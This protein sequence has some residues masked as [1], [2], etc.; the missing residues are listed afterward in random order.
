MLK[1]P[2]LGKQKPNCAIALILIRVN[3][4]HLERIFRE[5]LK[6][7]L[8]IHYCLDGHSSIKD[9]DFLISEQCKTHAQLKERETFRQRRLKTRYPLGLNE[10]EEHLY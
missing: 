5:F 1:S 7:L 3:T 9:R 6:K 8:Y 10:K 4:E 2:T